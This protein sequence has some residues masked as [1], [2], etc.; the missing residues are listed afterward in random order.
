MF[1]MKTSGGVVFFTSDI[2]GVK[3]AF[4]TRIGG[5][6]TLPHTAELNISYTSGGDK[7]TDSADIITE[8]RRRLAAACGTLPP[9]AAGYYIFTL[10]TK[11]LHSDTV[12]YV[13]P[14]NAANEF[15]CDGFVT[16]SPLAVVAV[17]TADCVPI[18]LADADAGIVS[19]VHAGWRG[20]AA[21]IAALAV[22]EMLRRGARLPYIQAAIGPAIGVCCYSVAPDFKE[23]FIKMMLTSRSEVTRASSDKAAEFFTISNGTH[24]AD[25]KA[26]NRLILESSG[27]KSENI[28]ICPLCTCCSPDLFYSHR[29]QGGSFGVMAAIITP[30][31]KSEGN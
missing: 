8:N 18:L 12:E 11:Q 2:L 24:R 9:Y 13:T 1:K 15:Y 28:D 17:K 14:N 21:G 16:D 4:S 26:I 10:A 20:T 23:T 22:D 7:G 3:H 19:A 29:R 6:S 25:L 27:I 31:K 5:V 30:D